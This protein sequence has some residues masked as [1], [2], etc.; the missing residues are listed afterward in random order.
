MSLFNMGTLG[1]LGVVPG[2]PGDE[3]H[4]PQPMVGQTRYVLER[5][6][7][8]G[9]SFREEVIPDTGHSPHMEKPRIFDP[10]FHA[11]LQSV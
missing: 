3:V 10:L 9:G 2:W 1:K 11:H 7:A 5:Y 8:N 6:R 4:P